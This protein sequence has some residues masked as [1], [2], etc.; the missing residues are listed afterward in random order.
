MANESKKSAHSRSPGKPEPTVIYRGIK[1][2][3]IYGKRSATARAIRDGLREMY[4][5]PRGKPANR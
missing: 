4:G 1:I 2:P 5:H 3:P